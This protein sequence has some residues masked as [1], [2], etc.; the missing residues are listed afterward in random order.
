LSDITAGEYALI[1]TT[2]D[3]NGE[4][5]A[6]CRRVL[7]FGTDKER[8]V[9]F[10]NALI[11]D[12]AKKHNITVSNSIVGNWV[13]WDYIGKARGFS[14]TIQAR[15]AE[16]V[17]KEYS[18]SEKVNILLYNL[19]P[20]DSKTNL[21]LGSSYASKAEK[22]LLY[23]DI[24]EPDVK[25]NFNGTE[26]SRKGEIVKQDENRFVEILRS[27]TTNEEDIYADFNAKDGFVLTKGN[28][29]DF[30]GVYSPI[31]K[32]SVFG[33][34]SYQIIDDVAYVKYAL[35]KSDNETVFE[36]YVNASLR[37]SE[38]NADFKYEFT[39]SITPNDSLFESDCSY[40]LL[41]LCNQKKEEIF[42]GKLIPVKINNSGNFIGNYDNS[43]WGKGFCDVINVLGQS[44]DG[45]ALHPDEFITRGSF[46]SMINRL[47]G[48]GISGKASFADLDE[49]NL[50]YG[51][52]ATAQAVG[53]LTGDE[54]GRVT[55]DELI[56]REQAMII[57]AR[58]SQADMGPYEVVFKDEDKISFWAKDY[59]DIMSSNG[60][61]SGFEGYLKPTNNITVAEASALIIKTFKWMHTDEEIFVPS[62]GSDASDNLSDVTVS[63]TE[64]ISDINFD[65]VSEFYSANA[66]GLLSLVLYIRKNFSDGIY[67]SKVGN[68]LEVR[69]YRI[70]NFI[71]LSDDATALITA[72]S[73]KFAEFS[74][75]YNPFSEDSVHFV[76]GRNDSG[77]LLGISYSPIGEPKNK[78]VTAINDNWYYFI[79]K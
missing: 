67:I 37:K 6:T 60:I 53:Y 11:K 58:I 63:G 57:L 40:L 24:G 74:I 31:I 3:I 23:Y 65:T 72:F 62:E 5:V 55:A 7:N 70:G 9:S 43:Y 1:I 54:N 71:K 50:Y 36:D 4:V 47:F 39:F 52:C 32:S 16:N 29:T 69:D 38:Y 34:N 77:K 10:D 46:A 49:T 61:V 2:T 27:E 14:Y 33:V 78:D 22:A 13:P 73:A 20:K 28:K 17:S 42:S 79:Q 12:Y 41:S 8:I 25:F 66:D 51:D 68:G 76:L 35:V 48:Y 64:F 15:F 18:A 56:S 19:N 45:D 75:R 21:K 44:P 26:L 30:Y 59:V